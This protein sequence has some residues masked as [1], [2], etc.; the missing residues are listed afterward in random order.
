MRATLFFICL[1]LFQIVAFVQCAKAIDREPTMWMA[2]DAPIRTWD[3]AVPLGNGLTGGLLWGQDNK[4][5]CRLTAAICG[6]NVYQRFTYRKIGITTRS[7][8]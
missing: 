6:T 3:E 7:A 1:I 2:L 4:S 8:N 5:I